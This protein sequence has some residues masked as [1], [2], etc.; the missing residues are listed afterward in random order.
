MK[1]ITSALVLLSTFLVTSTLIPHAAAQV[2]PILVWDVQPFGDVQIG[3]DYTVTAEVGVTGLP[4]GTYNVTI[5]VTNYYT[6]VTI[7][8]DGTVGISG[9]RGTVNILADFPSASNFDMG[10]IHVIV[11]HPFGG[12]NGVNGSEL[13]WFW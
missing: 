2:P 3:Q 8:T 1:T 10:D 9:G 4:D 5:L 6:P 11:H 13:I 12:P 7:Q